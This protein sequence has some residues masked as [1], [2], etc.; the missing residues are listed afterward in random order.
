M[1]VFK[2]EKGQGFVEYAI[3]LVLLAIIVIVILAF[4]TSPPGCSGEDQAKA[5]DGTCYTLIYVDGMPCYE[6]F[7]QLTCDWSRW[8]SNDR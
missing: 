6:H 7:H 8:E 1:N 5:S 4:V 2:N 3:L